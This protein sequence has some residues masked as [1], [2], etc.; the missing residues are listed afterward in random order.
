MWDTINKDPLIK[1]AMIIGIVF[2]IYIALTSGLLAMLANFS[3]FAFGIIFVVSITA[4]LLKLA[5]T[6]IA[7]SNQEVFQTSAVEKC[8]SACKH[9]IEDEWKFCP[10]CGEATEIHDATDE[11]I[12]LETTKEDLKTA[13]EA[14][15]NDDLVERIYQAQDNKSK[16]GKK[17]NKAAL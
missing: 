10:C 7:G 16:T 15:E 11:I 5:G 9:I 17:K 1:A 14:V 2:F 12:D 4:Y 8:C 3:I 6:S 13:A